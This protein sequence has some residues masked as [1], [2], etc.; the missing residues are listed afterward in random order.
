M[1]RRLAVGLFAAVSLA[2][3]G[4]RNEPRINWD[5]KEDFFVVDKSEPTEDGVRLEFHSLV[6]APPD[7]VYAALAD[8][9]H[10]AD[11]VDGVTH[12][13]V[14][15]IDGDVKIMDIT[16]TVIGRQSNAEVRWSADPKQQTVTFET[17]HSDANYND[18]SYRVIA[19]PGRNRAYVVSVFHVKEKGAPQNVPIGVL[20][21]ATRD[22][23]EKAANSVKQRALTEAK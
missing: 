18:G 23:F 4:C 22:A 19:S 14:V 13:K 11:F 7:R 6:D 15:R 9:E 17:L 16:Q 2:A 3:V 8:V 10:Y 21:A 1:S 12:S 20:A 5:G